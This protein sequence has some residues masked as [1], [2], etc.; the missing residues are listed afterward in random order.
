MWG[1]G[2]CPAAGLPPGVTWHGDAPRETTRTSASQG[3]IHGQRCG[4]ARSVFHSRRPHERSVHG[5]RLEEG[6][7]PPFKGSPGAEDPPPRSL[8]PA[9][10]RAKRTRFTHNLPVTPPMQAAMR[11][12]PP[13]IEIEHPIFGD[14]G[15]GI[16]IAFESQVGPEGCIGDFDDKRQ[17]VS[18]GMSERE[19][20]LGFPENREIRF[21]R[22]RVSN[23]GSKILRILQSPRMNSGRDW[24]HRRVPRRSRPRS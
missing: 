1:R 2:F 13:A 12:Q 18:T 24:R 8:H 5:Q 3:A 14:S 17:F 7:R 11:D 16:E 15:A 23:S 6:I 22:L 21:P 19:S 10:T 20:G 4:Q 9:G